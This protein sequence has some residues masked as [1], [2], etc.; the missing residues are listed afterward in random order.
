MSNK[1]NKLKVITALEN[2]SYQW[3]T[4]KGLSAETGL[5]E[6]LILSI[7][8]VSGDEVVKSSVA[9]KNGESLFSSRKTYRDKASVL[10]RFTS[11]LTN[12]GGV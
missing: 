3:R 8:N 2:P 5:D 7:I 10:D 1:E 11:A 12:K 4:V 9:G 6:A